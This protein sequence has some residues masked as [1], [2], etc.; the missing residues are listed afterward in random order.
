V[1][2]LP[3]GLPWVTLDTETSG[4]HPDD[5]ARVACVAL[6][7]KDWSVALPFDQGVRDKLPTAQIEL[8]LYGQDADPN[9]DLE[10]WEWLLRWLLDQ[11]LVFHNAKYDLTMMRTGTRHWPGVDLIDRLLWD[12]MVTNR[13]LWP[14]E[15][16]GLDVTLQRLALGAKVGLEGVI[17]W[18]AAKKYPKHRYDLVPWDVIRPYV[19][20]DAEDTDKL[21]LH[22]KSQLN[23]AGDRIDRALHLLQALYRMEERGVGYDDERSLAAAAQ[24]EAVALEIERT[25]PFRCAPKEAHFYFFSRLGLTP[26][27]ISE[28]TGKPSLDEEVVRQFVKDDVPYAREFNDVMRARRAVSMWYRGYPEKIGVDGRLRTDFKQTKVKSGRMSVGRIQLQA[29]PKRDK[30]NDLVSGERL[31]I[32]DGIPGVR[33]LIRPR[34]G[35]GLWNLDLSQAELRVASHYSQCRLMLKML[36]EGV[37]AHGETAKG[38]IGIDPSDPMWKEKRDIAK[39]LNFGGIFQ[40]GGEKFQMT[41]AKLADIHLSVEECDRYVRSWRRMYPEFGDAYRRADRMAAT[42]GYV[43]LLPNTPLEVRS[44]FSPRD[45]TNTAWNRIVQGSLAEAFGIWMAETEARWPGYMVLTIH[46]S[47]VLEAPLDEGDDLAA[48]V[49]EYGRD[50]TTELFGIEMKVDVDR[51]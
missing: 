12:T 32:Y 27:K 9:L 17:G 16:V 43:R 40:I 2:Q 48:R 20:N 50:M 51:W 18:L 13:I 41:L 6:A 8:D 15:D 34:E 30:Y 7:H 1:I 28:K 49:A 33:E 5:G 19:V 10:D 3:S 35:C 21:F 4:L 23:G 22:Q 14:T 11:N 38:V 42:K 45:Y 36:G 29:M 37:D 26:V 31:A 47:I 46:D 24:L 44:H 25:M 39:R